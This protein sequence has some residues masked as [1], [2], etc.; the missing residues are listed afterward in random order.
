MDIKQWHIN[1]ALNSCDKK[2]YVRLVSTDAY[3]LK[4]LTVEPLHT[5]FSIC[6]SY[7]YAYSYVLSW[8]A[9]DRVKLSNTIQ[10]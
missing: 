5:T 6:F 2:V 8:T 7:L 10:E 9:T 4:E 1:V 3:A